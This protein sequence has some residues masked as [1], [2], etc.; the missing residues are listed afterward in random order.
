MHLEIHGDQGAVRFDLE[1]MN[2]LEY[3]AVERGKVPR[4]GFRRILA[5]HPE[6]PYMKYWWPEGHIV[7]YEVTFA[8]QIHDW[9]DA[10][11]N[12]RPA[13]PDFADGLRCQEVVDAIVASTVESRITQIVHQNF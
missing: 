3:Y 2:E 12:H 5:T 6:H 10:I 4:E 9:V 8:H 1:R 11:A 13:S 7:G